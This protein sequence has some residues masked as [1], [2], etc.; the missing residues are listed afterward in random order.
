MKGEIIGEMK[1]MPAMQCREKLRIN[2]KH[3]YGIKQIS[4]LRNCME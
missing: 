4:R 2:Q 3:S 1:I